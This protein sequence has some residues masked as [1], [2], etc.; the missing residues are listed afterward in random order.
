MYSLVSDARNKLYD[1]GLKT[2][3][4]STLPVVSV[5][6]VTMG[7]SGK[8]PFVDYLCD[9]LRR[10]YSEPVILLRGYGG[11]KSG[12]HIVTANDS[13]EEVGDEAL[14]H[15]ELLGDRVPVVVSRRR[16][17]GA[18]VIERNHLG[19]VIVLDDGLQHRSLVRDLEIVV[20]DLS[21]ERKRMLWKNGLQIPAGTLRESKTQALGRADCIVIPLRGAWELRSYPYYR[22]LSNSSAKL[23]VFGFVLRASHFT[24]LQNRTKHHLS[25]LAGR[26]VVLASAVADPRGFEQMA[27]R[28]KVKISQVVKFGDHHDYRKSDWTKLIRSGQTILTTAKDAVKLKRFVSKENQVLVLHLAGD[29][30]SNAERDRFWELYRNRVPFGETESLTSR[31]AHA[32]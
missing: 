3:Y 9:T 12:P 11:T 13:A 15:R 7:G 17:D 21:T 26:E 29:F 28:L 22:E 32:G 8:S 27:S 14:M 19:N 6:N 10:D 30:I 31:I 24:D 4:R 20:V 18:K 23:P 25:A 1:C 5:G 2:S 16:I